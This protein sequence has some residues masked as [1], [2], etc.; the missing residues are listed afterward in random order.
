[1]PLYMERTEIPAAQTVAE[2]ADKLAQ[3]AAVRD[4]HTEY[5]HRRIR[6]VRFSLLVEDRKVWYTLPANTAP[7]FAYLQAKRTHATP[8]GRQI[9]AEKAERIAWRQVLRW[10][11]AQLG[12]IETGMVEPAEVFL[13]YATT[14]TTEG[15]PV[16]VYQLWRTTL[17]LPAPATA[18]PPAPPAHKQADCA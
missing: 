3:H 7:I 1:M 5:E 16:T 4:V 8:E 15:E 14:K 11:E 2:I 6:A 18:P 13:P 17:A 10:I 9:D 12:M